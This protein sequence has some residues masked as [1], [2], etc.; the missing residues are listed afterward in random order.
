MR[1]RP[2]VV[3][4]VVLGVSAVAGAG[5][6]AVQYLLHDAA[7]SGQGAGLTAALVT[8][9]AG[10]FGLPILWLIGLSLGIADRRTNPGKVAAV[11]GGLAL[12]AWAVWFVFL[13]GFGSTP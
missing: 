3:G 5:L 13:F 12:A 11:L 2:G 7:S 4:C 9:F 8:F 1:Y 6:V 10:V